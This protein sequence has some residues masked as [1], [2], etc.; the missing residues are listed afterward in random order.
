MAVHNQNRT[1][2]ST[3]I[4]FSEITGFSQIITFNKYFIRFF[5]KLYKRN[6]QQQQQKKHLEFYFTELF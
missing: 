2:N 5:F 4:F 3:L 1:L 6:E